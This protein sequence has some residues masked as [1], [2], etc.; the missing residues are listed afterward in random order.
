MGESLIALG[1]DLLDGAEPADSLAPLQAHRLRLYYRVVG[2][3]DDGICSFVHID[4][5]GR[6]FSAEHREFHRYPMRYWQ[7]GDVLV[8]E[9]AVTLGGNFTP[10]A[11][12]LRYGLDRLPCDGHARLA[13]KSGPHDADNRIDGGNIHVR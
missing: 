4:G 12:G 2:R 7:P 11:Y 13:V 1:W 3:L 6:R 9:F 5:Q 10:G 8:D